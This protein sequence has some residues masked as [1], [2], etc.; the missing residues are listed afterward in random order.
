[1]AQ[2]YLCQQDVN[3][4]PMYVLA[5]NGEFASHVAKGLKDHKCRRHNFYKKP[6][7]IVQNVIPFLILQSFYKTCQNV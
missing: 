1:M 7:S 6:K 3:S 4:R 2:N 5:M